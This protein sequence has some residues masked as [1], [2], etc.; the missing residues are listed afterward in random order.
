L[1]GDVVQTDDA[2]LCFIDGENVDAWPQTCPSGVG[3]PCPESDIVDLNLAE[4][5]Q[6]NAGGTI[7]HVDATVSWRPWAPLFP[8]ANGEGVEGAAF[9]FDVPPGTGLAAVVGGS[10]GGRDHTAALV[11]QE[12]AHL[13]GLEPPESPHFDGSGHSKDPVLVDPFAFDF[14]LLKPYVPPTGQALGDVMSSGWGQGRDLVLYNVF[15]WEFLRNRLAAL[16]A[17]STRMGSARR[18]SARQR[19]VLVDS[20]RTRFDDEPSVDV[21]RPQT[22]LPHQR[23]RAWEWTRS[24]FQ[25]VT[26]TRSKGARSGFGADAEG[27]LA[28]I[29]DLGIEE[30]HAPIGDRPL[31]MVVSPGG[32]RSVHS[33]EFHA[34]E[35][36]KASPRRARRR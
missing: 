3:P 26:A 19:R 6:I 1:R 24:G 22:A 15:D 30:I 33:S 21:R 29:A 10:R 18:P 34:F 17:P 9:Y 20:L 31:S 28:R 27:F 7:Q 2:G 12:V 5:R 4:T 35:F 11:A 32:Y 23:R 16:W 25:S 36:A 8:A 14:Y 13:F